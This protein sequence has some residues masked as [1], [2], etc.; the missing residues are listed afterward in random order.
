MTTVTKLLKL[1]T[2]KSQIIHILDSSAEHIRCAFF[3]FIRFVA[4]YRD[5]YFVALRIK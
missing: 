5:F 4:I 3:L 2:I 1:K